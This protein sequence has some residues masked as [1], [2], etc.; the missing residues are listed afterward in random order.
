VALV[1]GAAMLALCTLGFIA[2]IMLS[3]NQGQVSWDGGPTALAT[4][5]PGD[6][7]TPA[8]PAT[9]PA[10]GPGGG[11][12][13]AVA[14]GEGLPP[15]RVL[16]L[17]YA[18][19]MATLALMEARG[20]LEAEGYDLELLDAYAAD[21][22]L[23]EEGQCQA[24]K[25]GSVEALATTLDATR[26]CGEGVA[27]G[28][29][30]GQSAGNDA[31]VVKPGVESWNDV[32]EHAVAMTGYSVSE[33][34]AC[35]ASH[36]ANQPVK[37]AL[38]FDDAAQAVDAWQA[39]GA[40]QDIQSV[41][42]WQPEVDRALAAVPGSRVI[43]SSDDVRVLWDVIE[44]STA[45]AAAD[46]AAY[47]AFTRAY[48]RALLDLSRD[49]VGALEAIVA[50]AG[51]DEGRQ[52]L[53][54]T[55]DPAEFRDQLEDEAFATLRDANIL[56]SD[57]QT[58]RNRL[59]EAAFY[60][61]YCNVPVPELADV[62]ALVLPQFVAGAHGNAALLGNPEERPS[63]QVFQV[64]DFTD[65]AAVTDA[66]IQEAQVLFQSGVDIEFVP[67]R[68]DFRD[69][70]AANRV[71][72]EAVRFLRICQ[73][74]VLEIQGGAA[75]PG[76]RVCPNCNP[77]DS[78]ALAIQRGRRV[79]EELQQ[80]FDVPPGQLRFVEAPHTPQFPGSNDDAQL[81]QDRRTFLT[82]YQLGGR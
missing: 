69:P 55:T 35:F 64:T 70:N 23:D 53:L 29:P 32:F 57:L 58:L 78:D 10:A 48:Y 34:M 46:P 15:F 6:D 54:T 22:D 43:L 9:R 11:A 28:I 30:V 47:E 21:V 31:I 24:V 50:W 14:S 76:D 82:G 62:A 7:A 77:A 19:Y 13:T 65:R 5:Y 42:A 38:R 40:E 80:R 37:L 51:Q 4:A 71:L 33:F 27:I 56:M 79:Y 63:G 36:T 41:V 20:Y 8:A 60:W 49:P 52:A 16:T 59:D 61:R 81:R 39:Q 73:D 66:D 12:G 25:E 1:I 2:S 67:N 44:F 75:Y 45:R 74:C 18:P 72:S 68:T 3:T 26:K 17:A